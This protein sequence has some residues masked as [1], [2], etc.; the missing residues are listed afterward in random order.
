MNT[1]FPDPTWE[2]I[3][4]KYQGY[5]LVEEYYYDDI[6]DKHSYRYEFDFNLGENVVKLCINDLT[7]TNRAGGDSHKVS[8]LRDRY[9]QVRFEYINEPKFNF[10]LYEKNFFLSFF[11]KILFKNISLKSTAL[12]SRFSLESNKRKVAKKLI[13]SLLFMNNIE[14]ISWVKNDVINFKTAKTYLVVSVNNWI[15]HTEAIEKLIEGSSHLFKSTINAEKQIY[16]QKYK[17]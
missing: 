8:H 4:Q 1:L 17:K 13:P 9:L 7:T 12:E 5:N 3:F 10:S 16:Y 14:N 2:E 15:R 11:D 6:F